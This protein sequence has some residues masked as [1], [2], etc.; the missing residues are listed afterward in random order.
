MNHTMLAIAYALLAAAP[1]VMQLGLTLGAPWGR[2]TLG[3][4]F[5]GSLPRAWRPVALV[6][7]ALLL[8]LALIML[9]WGDVITLPLPRI[10]FWLAFGLTVITTIA[11]LATPSRPER[12]LWGP[13]TL[14]MSLCALGLAFT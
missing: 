11:N 10:A 8:A 14:G 3:G 4:R 1:F 9:D 12:M 2:F 5:P 7:A 6:Q 13:V